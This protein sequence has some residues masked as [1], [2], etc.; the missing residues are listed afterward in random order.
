M[1][2][3]RQSSVDSQITVVDSQ[4]TGI[5]AFA[6]GEPVDPQALTEA[7]SHSAG[8]EHLIDL[9]VLRGLVGG[10]NTTRP[11][12][13]S[14]RASGSVSRLR[15]LAVAAS[16]A[17]ISVLGGYVLGQRTTEVPRVPNAVTAAPDVVPV[18]APAPTRIIRLE[19]GV[20]W[21]ERTGGG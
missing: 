8:R 15:R 12:L 19:N 6:D 21:N 17:G 13:I 5:E 16:V 7:L 4:I 18:S 14:S 3:S 11:V 9:L 20:D 1:R 2:D 10:Q